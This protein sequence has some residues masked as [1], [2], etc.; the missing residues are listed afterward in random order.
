M[1][2]RVRFLLSESERKTRS[3]TVMDVFLKRPGATIWIQEV[4]DGTGFDK[5]RCQTTIANLRQRG[6][7][8]DTVLKG[9]AYRYM[10]G[11]VTETP[12]VAPKR[13]ETA[14][15]VD[16]VP[17]NGGVIF[18]HI[19]TTKSGELLLAGTDGRWYAAR[20]LGVK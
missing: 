16:P 6:I 12:P 14:R 17:L 2:R 8:I 1:K 5:V 3:S 20:E 4:M 11:Q 9:Q 18:E 15:V 13:P 7:P 19:A 10:A